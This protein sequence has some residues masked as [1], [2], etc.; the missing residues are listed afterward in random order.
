MAKEELVNK[1]DIALSDLSTDGGLLEP[2]QANTFIRTLIKQPTLLN[3]IR[4]VEMRAPTFKAPKIQFGSRVLRRAVS[5]SALAEADRAKPDT[6]EVVLTSQEV[7]AEVRL[8]YDVIE[9]NVER[10]NLGQEV[11]GSGGEGAP[12][13]GGMVDTVR[14][15]IVEAVSRDL[16]ELALRGDETSTDDYLSLLDGYIATLTANGNVVDNAGAVVSRDMFKQGLQA[17][18]P[19]FHRERPNMRHM[20]S[21]NNEIEYRETV[22]NRETSLGD[23]TV[24]AFNPVFGYGVPVQPVQLMPE[25][26]GILGHP[27][28]FLFG[29]QRQVYLEYEKLISERVFKI[30]ITA[31]ID[32]EVEEAEASAVFNNIGQAA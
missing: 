23:A 31:R 3:I 21:V 6:N 32:F 30:V 13:G 27:M 29:I 24:T 10:G 18:P 16:E 22:A 8:P 26:H 1:A 9:D 15:L 28:N 2:Q 5:G 14:T 25:D 12:A 7:I 19:Q 11:D 17:I 20:L 4:T